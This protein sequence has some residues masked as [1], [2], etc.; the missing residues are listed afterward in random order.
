MAGAEVLYAADVPVRVKVPEREDR[1][2]SLS[3]RIT[4]SA[5][6]PSSRAPATLLLQLTDAADALLLYTLEISEDEYHAIKAEH[7]ILVD[8][9][10]F[11]PKLAELLE[12]CSR[13]AEESERPS[14]VA[15]LR[16]ASDAPSLAVHEINSFS[17]LPHLTLRLRPATDT[18]LKKHLAELVRSL[19]ADG[20]AA[21]ALAAEHASGRA[22]AEVTA[23][24]SRDALV[25]EQA[26][27]EAAA[28]DAAAG[29]AQALA[30]ARE[31]ATD[32]A[33]A[34]SASAA[35]ELAT[36]RGRID[37]ELAETRRGLAQAASANDALTAAKHDL[38]MR[39][40]AA[41]ARLALAEA[42]RKGEAEAHAAAL[43]LS[44]LGQAVTDRDEL[45]A[46]T[47]ALLDAAT[48]AKQ[49]AEGSLAEA[50]ARVHRL[51]LK[52]EHAVNEISKGNEIIERLQ[53]DAR[54]SR[55]KSKSRSAAAAASAAS[56]AEA[57]QQLDAA[58]LM[59]ERQRADLA[60]AAAGRTRAEEREK[61]GGRQLEEA[62]AQLQSNQQV[63][64]AQLGRVSS[65]TSSAALS[66]A[67]SYR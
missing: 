61:E 29:R 33:R 50:R 34:A 3:V 64:D 18:Q 8:F 62:H 36:E 44:A 21:K 35:T 12:R 2:S 5:S 37:A 26:Q 30:A 6:G 45:A 9:H 52:L 46:K 16:C 38:A 63:T 13:A 49:I 1:S 67:S 55:A 4:Q 14:F 10:Q 28:R 53:A 23:R 47:Q 32:A 19:R 56:L 60:E 65:A 54:A 42:E 41:S 66:A 27:R 25:A 58:A 43:E 39:H 40:A 11:A 15:T 48:D 24:D 17:Q 57:K 59:S 51:E 7:S 22:E 31:Q 20:A